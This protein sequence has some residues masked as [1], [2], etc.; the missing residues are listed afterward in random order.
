MSEKVLDSSAV[1]AYLH[2]EI[3]WEAVENTLQSDDCVI[4]TVNHSEIVSKLAEK[5]LPEEA[6]SST[7]DAL[8]LRAIDFD[9]ALSMSAG[10]LREPTKSTG[11]SLGDR[12]CLV[13]AR[14]RKVAALT[15]DRVW[16]DLDIGVAITIIR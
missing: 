15:A 8:S 2:K 6:I 12:A 11:L 7:L 3:G 5:G 14:Q 9:S 4:S 1:L 10:L 16:K 13:L